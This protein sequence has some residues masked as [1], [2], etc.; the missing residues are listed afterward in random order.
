M[1]TV[2]LQDLTLYMFEDHISE[3]A[4]ES[5][6]TKLIP[7]GSV[8]CVVR[9]GILKYSF[10]V[11]LLGRDMCINQDLIAFTPTTDVVISKFLFYVLKTRSSSIIEVGIKPGVTVQSFYNGFFRDYP[12][13]L[14]PVAT[15]HAIVSEIEAEQALVAANREVI[16]RFEEKI[17]TTLARVWGEDENTTG[18]A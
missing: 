16:A 4:V 9:S 15:Q 6:A 5:S 14:P 7:A 2:L 13:P 8:V 18:D 17:Q 1:T 3:A 11:A 10:P 12:I